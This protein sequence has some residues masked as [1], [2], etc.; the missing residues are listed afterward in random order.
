MLTFSALRCWKEKGT[1]DN[2]GVYSVNFKTFWFLW[3]CCCIES[4][5]TKS[6][7]WRYASCAITLYIIYD[8]TSSIFVLLTPFDGYS[9]STVQSQHQSSAPL[10]KSRISIMLLPMY[11]Q[12]ELGLFSISRTDCLDVLKTLFWTTI[13]SVP[14]VNGKPSR[15]FCFP[16][17]TFC[18][19]A[20]GSFNYRPRNIV[21]SEPKSDPRCTSNS[22]YLLF[23]CKYT[24]KFTIV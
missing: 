5:V 2:I 11:L 10:E 4:L 23:M 8:N 13:C 6:A 24:V 20:T 1:E 9:F 17:T 15:A 18:Q 7:N 21:L 12:K 16:A 3:D 14:T 19:P 22:K